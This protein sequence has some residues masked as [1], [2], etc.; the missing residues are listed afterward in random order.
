MDAK[1]RTKLIT[2][3][4]AERDELERQAGERE[5][6]A[7]RL[8]GAQKNSAQLEARSLR[9]RAKEVDRRWAELNEGQRR[10]K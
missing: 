10:V 9:Q 3:L 6:R 4:A 5:K 2:E 8:S 7:Q 1:A